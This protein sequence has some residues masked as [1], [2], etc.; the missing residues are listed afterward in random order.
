MDRRPRITVGL[1]VY[2]G[3]RYVGDTI[4]SVLAQTFEDFELVI[5]DNASTDGT[6]QVCKGYAARDARVRYYQQARNVGVAENFNHVFHLASSELFKWIAAD[7]PIDPTYL[8]RCI[9]AIDDSPSALVVHCRIRLIDQF[10]EHIADHDDQLDF[11]SS[12]PRR[13]FREYLFRRAGMW[14]AVY[15]VMRS[16][17]LAQT[18]LHGGYIASDQVLLGELVVRGEIHQL[19]ERLATRRLHDRQ[20]WRANASTSALALWYNPSS[21]GRVTVNW[22]FGLAREYLRMLSRVQLT[23]TD[24][25]S[26]YADVISWGTRVAFLRPARTWLRKRL[27][28]GPVASR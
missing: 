26:C 27:A 12:S 4:E 2:N 3:E 7:D 28:R 15:G 25:L 5:S 14:T 16:A 13:R 24:R 19:P 22:Q 6:Q 9:Q 18:C 10:G 20:S 11:R 21:R 17:V 23:A 8:A 1:P